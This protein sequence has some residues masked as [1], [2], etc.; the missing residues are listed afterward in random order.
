MGLGRLSAEDKVA[1]YTALGWN[2]YGDRRNEDAVEA[3]EAGVRLATRREG[4]VSAEVKAGA[5][6]G[7]GY[8]NYRVFDFANAR[9]AWE[10]ERAET[11]DTQTVLQNL[12]TLEWRLG[13]LDE[14]SETVGNNRCAN[15][16]ISLEERLREQAHLEASLRLLSLIHI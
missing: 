6:S 13:T 7:A 10:A 2:H 16:D 4:S 3:F 11:G 15:S 5:L 14:T 12:A 9:D 1:A 8:A